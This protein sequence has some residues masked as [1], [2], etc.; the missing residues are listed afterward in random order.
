VKRS[1][2]LLNYFSLVSKT[3]QTLVLVSREGDNELCV[4]K[5][6]WAETFRNYFERNKTKAEA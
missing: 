1:K 4:E 5:P 3:S 2:S 6:I